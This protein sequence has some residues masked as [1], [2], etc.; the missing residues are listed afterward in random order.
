M[1]TSASAERDAVRDDAAPRAVRELAADLLPSTREISQGL[2]E[3][4]T[5]ALPELAGGDDELREEMLA[6]AEANIDQVLRLLR[7]GADADALVVPIEVAQYVRGLV[8]RGVTLPVLLRSYRL[9]HAWIWDRWSQALHDRIDSLEDLLAAQEQS[10][11]FMF[12]YVDRISGI[13]VEDYG[14]ERERMA[15][16]AAQLRGDTVRSI[17]AGEPVDEELAVQRLGYELRR[18]HVAL[19]VSSSASEVRGLERAARE[20]AAALGPGEPLVIPSGVASLDVWCGSYEPPTAAALEGYVPPDGVRVAFGGSGRDVAGFRRT[21][22]EAMQAA[23]VAALAGDSATAVTSYQR[24]ELVSLLA[25]D[26]PSARRFVA[27][28]LGPLA[29]TAEPAERLRETVLA[30]LVAG[31]SGTRAA[32]E[33]Y[34]HQNTVTYRVKRAEELM[35]RRVNHNPVEL[36]CALTLAAAL[37]AAVLADEVSSR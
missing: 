18:H 12:S 35:G 16:G 36:V 14:S 2:V 28:Q 8:R 30:F 19:R 26:L 22:A 4:L 1:A 31:G 7:A 3:H 24:V 15:R 20:A 11:A 32:K 10:S 25:G 27:A 29:S 6:S 5:A 9:G 21:H 17:L 33:L 37:G 23:R 34:V 13:L